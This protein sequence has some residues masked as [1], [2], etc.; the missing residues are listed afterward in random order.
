MTHK[1]M[2]GMR[3]AL[4]FCL[5]LGV[6]A[7]GLG[8][9]PARAEGDM[10]SPAVTVNGTVVTRYEVAQRLAFL[11][12]L[13]QTGDLEKRAVEDLIADRLQMDAAKSLGVNISDQDVGA[14]MTEFAARANLSA[15]DF[16]KAI[17]DAGVEPQSFRDFVKAGLVWRAVLR[18]KFS[19]R[20]KVTDAE[21]DRRIAEGGASG[22][23]LRA[24]LSELILLDDGTG[25][26]LALAVKI[27]EKMKTPT[28]FSNA[29]RIFSKGKTAADGGALGWIDTTT[30]PPVVATALTG[31]KTGDITAPVVLQGA[32]AMY[33]VRDQSIAA[34]DAK[35]APQVDYAVFRPAAGQDLTAVQGKATDCAGLDVAARGLPEEALQLLTSAEAAVPPALRGVLAGLDAGESAIVAGVGGVG[36]L[37]ML[38]SRIPQSIVPASRDDVQTALV[39]EKLALMATA[40]MQ[41][42]RTQAII[43]QE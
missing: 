21:V 19:G 42:L 1:A 11:Q 35:G 38:C 8:P 2:I 20:L 5:S 14:G 32:V 33:L 6:L 24:M 18:A 17:G 4:A 27:R 29:A 28:D 9:I 10:F 40:Y 31:L 12:V 15:E 25:T 22:G 37:V 16:I 23:N 41:E 39:N 36:E 43:V 7:L 13:Q 34:G 30:L 26:A 3:L